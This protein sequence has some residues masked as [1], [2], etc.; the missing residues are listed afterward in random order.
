MSNMIFANNIYELRKQNNLTQ[1][2]MAE[3]CNVTRHGPVIIGL[4]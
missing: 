2:Q 3:L 4:N 1:E